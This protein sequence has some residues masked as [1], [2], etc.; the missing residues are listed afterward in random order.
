MVI[1]WDSS[2]GQKVHMEMIEKMME[3]FANAPKEEFGKRHPGETCMY[4]R[5]TFSDDIPVSPW[6]P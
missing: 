1:S 5:K 2:E 3:E 4:E 6:L